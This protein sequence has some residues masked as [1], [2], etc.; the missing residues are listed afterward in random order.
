MRSRTD[1]PARTRPITAGTR[2]ARSRASG[3]ATAAGGVAFPRAALLAGADFGARGADDVLDALARGLRAGGAPSPDVCP[4]PHPHDGDRRA[5]LGA[6]AEAGFDERMRAARALIVC[7]RSLLPST[8]ASTLAF[9]LA[10]RARQ[11]GVPAFAVCEQNR[12]G[13][14]DA[15]LLDL[16]AILAARG[17]RGLHAAG[18][19]LARLLEPSHAA[20]TGARV[21]PPLSAGSP[22]TRR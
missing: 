22:G 15:R 13:A 20:S 17:P 11:A 21:R 1:R 3:R 18:R 6:L 8:L 12:L 16:Q 14:F 2:P 9:E 5:T 10:T 4:L 19:R 7:E